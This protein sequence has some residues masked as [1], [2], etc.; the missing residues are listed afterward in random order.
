ML[1]PIADIVRACS[2][3]AHLESVPTVESRGAPLRCGEA[4][5]GAPCFLSEV[6]GTAS[7]RRAAEFRPGSYCDRPAPALG[8]EAKELAMITRSN[9]R[10]FSP[11]IGTE[12]SFVRFQ[13]TGRTS[14]RQRHSF[15][16]L[17]RQGSSLGH[18][19]NQLWKPRCHTPLIAFVT[20]L[21]INLAW[22]SNLFF[23]WW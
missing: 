19:M 18:A 6:V 23:D 2:H 4:G 1:A 8:R 11:S 3:L 21:A 5:I 9:D 20:L 22:I 16:A 15:S 10:R 7:K 17:L 14:A 12:I 13:A